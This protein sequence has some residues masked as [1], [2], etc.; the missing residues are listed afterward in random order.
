MNVE[1]ST[2]CTCGGQDKKQTVSTAC[3]QTDLNDVIGQQ[4]QL[5]KNEPLGVVSG[6][7]YSLCLHIHRMTRDGL[8][9]VDRLELVGVQHVGMLRPMFQKLLKSAFPNE[10]PPYL[11]SDEYYLFTPTEE[12]APLPENIVHTQFRLVAA[13]DGWETVVAVRDLNDFSVPVEERKM[14]VTMAEFDSNPI[15]LEDGT[16]KMVV[17]VVAYPSISI[18]KTFL[19]TVILHLSREHKQFYSSSAFNV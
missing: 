1:M 2:F 12:F 11:T 15:A 16:S 6:S 14:M 7:Q 13:V 19:D 10:L 18:E 8:T 4:T 3:I 5:R 9:K 17:S